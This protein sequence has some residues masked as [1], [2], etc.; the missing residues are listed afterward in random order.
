MFKELGKKGGWNKEKE[1][2]PKRIKSFPKF[3]EQ[4]PNL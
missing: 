2:Q 4:T 1:N 3:I